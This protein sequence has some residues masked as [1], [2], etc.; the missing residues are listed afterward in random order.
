MQLPSSKSIFW[1]DH[2]QEA[3]EYLINCLTKPPIMA[4]PDFNSP[5]I[6]HANA[7]EMGLGAVL[8]QCQ[9]GTSRVI[10]YGSHTLTPAEKNYHLHS[11]ASLNFW[12]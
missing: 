2:H 5:F 10:A 3:L 12:Y 8:Y 6:L 11:F 9:D 4:Y 1:A 7:S